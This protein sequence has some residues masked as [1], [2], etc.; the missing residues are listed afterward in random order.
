M[1]KPKIKI[2]ISKQRI[3]TGLK[4]PSMDKAKGVIIEN[5]IR[6][7]GIIQKNK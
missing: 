7:K 2:R 1:D 6:E 4:D 5:K 3:D